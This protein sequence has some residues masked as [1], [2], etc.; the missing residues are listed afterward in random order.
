ME[1]IIMLIGVL[2]SMLLGML[3]YRQGLKDSRQINATGK[4]NKL[5]SGKPIESEQSDFDK[6]LENMLNYTGDVQVDEEN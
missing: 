6:S 3:I 2:G 5:I 4:L 1:L